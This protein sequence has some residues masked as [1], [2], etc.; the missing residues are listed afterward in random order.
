[1]LPDLLDQYCDGTPKIPL[2]Y[3]DKAC[4]AD[5]ADVYDLCLSILLDLIPFIFQE[6]L[7]N[8]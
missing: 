7:R 4:F 8:D 5:K 2:P 3:S 6:D 1:M